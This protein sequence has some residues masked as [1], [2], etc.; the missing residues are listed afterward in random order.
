VSATRCG[1]SLRDRTL[2]ENG[3]ISC[4]FGLSLSFLKQMG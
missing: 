4:D 2:Q 3:F 1:F